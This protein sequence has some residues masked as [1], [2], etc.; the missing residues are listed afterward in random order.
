[1][2]DWYH[3][4][5]DWDHL[6]NEFDTSNL[7]DMTVTNIIPILLCTDRRNKNIP[8]NFQAAYLQKNIGEWEILDL[9]LFVTHSLPWDG[10]DESVISLWE[11]NYIRFPKGYFLDFIC[12]ANG[13][14]QDLRLHFTP[15]G[16]KQIFHHLRN[17][18]LFQILMK[19]VTMIRSMK[20]E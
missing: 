11:M 10:E 18:L 7:Q 15:R 16:S 14:N 5:L 20:K 19:T 17:N 8:D 3:Y 9:Q 2:A 1:M 13:L 4:L 6:S 12:S